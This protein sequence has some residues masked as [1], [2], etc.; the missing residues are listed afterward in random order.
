MAKEVAEI[1]VAFKTENGSW[2]AKRIQDELRRMG[3]KV[4]PTRTMTTIF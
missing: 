1:I 2:G 4:R 3:I